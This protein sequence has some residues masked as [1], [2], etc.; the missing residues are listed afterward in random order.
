M[1]APTQEPTML[2]V[3]ERLDQLNR[4]VT[5]IAERQLKFEEF[6]EE[7]TP[8]GKEVLKTASQKLDALEK[9]GVVDFGKELLAV[10][11]KVAT[12]YRVEDVRQLGDAVV[13]IL[14]TVRAMTQPEI[15]QAASE[16]AEVLQHADQTEPI[17]LVGMVR[18]TRNEDVQ[19]GMAVMMEVMRKVGQG[20]SA[21]NHRRAGETDRK[22]KLQKL[23]GSKRKVLGVERQLPSG[24][25]PVVKMTAPE[26]MPNQLAC[27]VPAKPQPVAAVLDG[28]AFTADGSLADSS[29]WTKELGSTIA[30]SLGVTMT[31]AHWAL[32]D[33]ARRD[34]DQTKASP[35]IRRITQGTNL[36]T[37]DIYSLFPKAPAR[38]VSKIAGIPKP[39][40]CL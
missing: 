1:N 9:E 18:A 19:R 37:K 21:A 14:D 29:Q 33:F 10:G 15:L 39:A 32:V 38:T 30:A 34:F 23:L 6:V 27:A 13:S 28:V 40:G 24:R 12:T 3:L 25:A 5:Q 11:R 31:E 35:N 36:T 17:G 8:I 7:F 4:Q 16:A 26:A 2:L 20:V 22:A